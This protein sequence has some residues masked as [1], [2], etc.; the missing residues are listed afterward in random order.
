MSPRRRRPVNAC[1][2]VTS[3]TRWRSIASTL[4][5]PVPSATTWSSQIFSTSVRGRRCWSHVSFLPGHGR[6]FCP[7]ATNP[8]PARG[9]YFWAG[10]RGCQKRRT[11]WSVREPGEPRP[12]LSR[13]RF[14]SNHRAPSEGPPS[15]DTEPEAPEGWIAAL[16]AIRPAARVWLQTAFL[17]GIAAIIWFVLLNDLPRP[18]HALVAWPLLAAAFALAELKVVEVHFRRETHA[19]SLSSSRRSSASSRCRRPS[20]SSRSS[21]DAAIALIWLERPAAARKLAFN[22]SNFRV[23]RRSRC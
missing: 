2:L 23:S 9:Q 11:F 13:I 17:A 4:G 7:T 14:I 20:T 22:L 1:G 8:R 6:T 16:H 15:P 21:P 19:F 10:V 12:L 18:A 3:W 5:A